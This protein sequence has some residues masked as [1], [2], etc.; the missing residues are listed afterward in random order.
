[1]EN[2]YL[3]EINVLFVQL[4]AQEPC[5][6]DKCSPDYSRRYKTDL[7]WCKIAQ[8][9]K[10]KGGFKG[11][12]PVLPPSVIPLIP[13]PN[14]QPDNKGSILGG[15]ACLER[16]LLD[17]NPSLRKTAEQLAENRFPLC[18]FKH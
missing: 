18:T 5:L 11:V 4:T 17:E 14:Q 8:D 6:Y 7:A 13:F 3:E 15:V 1:M 2:K 16:K 10:E 12:N 9:M